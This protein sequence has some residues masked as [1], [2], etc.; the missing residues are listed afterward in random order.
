[1]IQSGL[2]PLPLIRAHGM[3]MFATPVNKLDGFGD[4][5]MNPA[6]PTAPGGRPTLSAI[7]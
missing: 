3:R 4:G 5:P 2:L 1:M 7:N 6:Q